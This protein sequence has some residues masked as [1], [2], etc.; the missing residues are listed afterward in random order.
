[1]RHYFSKTVLVFIMAI[2][3]YLL[4]DSGLFVTDKMALTAITT[5]VILLCMV[6]YSYYSSDFNEFRNE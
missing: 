2:L 1:M 5:F 3:L 6:I 4:I